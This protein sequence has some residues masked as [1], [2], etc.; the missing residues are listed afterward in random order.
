[1]AKK[2]GP[3]PKARKAYIHNIE[4]GYNRLQKVLKDH[5]RLDEKGKLKK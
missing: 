2:S 1:M 4:K 5:G 3:T